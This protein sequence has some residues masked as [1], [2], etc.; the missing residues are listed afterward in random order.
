[1]KNFLTLCNERFSVR[2]Y[3]TLRVVEQ[4]KVDYVLS[5]ARLAPSAVNKQSWHIY[6]VGP[7]SDKREMI[8]QCYNRD[9]FKSAP[10]YLLLTSRHD[11]SWKRPC[12]N[13]DHADIDIAIQA[14]H[15]CLAATEVG[16]GTCW[17]CNFDAPLCRQLFITNPD[18]EPAVI[19]PLGYPAAELV[20]PEKKRMELNQLISVI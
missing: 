14:E 11:L 4:D 19:I 20:A 3:D 18:E 9:W 10:Y 5:C 13:K 6:I 7:E 17:V 12:D 15:I 2:A 8:Q 1:M 16:L